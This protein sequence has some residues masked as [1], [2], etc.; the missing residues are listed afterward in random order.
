[1][2]WGLG[3]SLTTQTLPDVSQLIS[4]SQLALGDIL[5]YNSTIDPVN[6]SHVVMFVSWANP[7][8]TIFT[9]DEEAGGGTG[10]V[11]RTIPFPYD[12]PLDG[13][14]YWVPYRY[15]NMS[16]AAAVTSFE[17]TAT[18]PNNGP[19][20]PAAITLAAHARNATCY[21]FSS[22]NTAVTG[23]E[24]V[25]SSSGEAQDQVSIP[26]NTS[27]SQVTYTFSVTMIGPDGSATGRAVFAQLSTTTEVHVSGGTVDYCRQ[28]G[29]SPDN[30]SSYLACTP[31]NGTTF[32]PTVSSGLIDWGYINGSEQWV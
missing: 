6:G 25:A 2:A 16:D 17:A 22:D 4:V 10:A 7:Q 15:N 27:G 29:A 12:K 28:T 5:V 32:G 3:D 24:T 26:M 20:F 8:H 1:M 19:G 31:F 23:L 13:S 14:S 11:Q 21:V 18:N 9:E 30:V